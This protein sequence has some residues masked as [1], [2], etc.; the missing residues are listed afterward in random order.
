M[1]RPVGRR[2]PVDCSLGR[3][4]LQQRVASTQNVGRLRMR[5]RVWVRRASLRSHVDDLSLANVPSIFLDGLASSSG[6]V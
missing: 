4:S 6:P 5:D 3:P 2:T 1:S